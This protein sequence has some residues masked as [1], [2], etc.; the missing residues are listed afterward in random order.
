M[1]QRPG[2]LGSSLL[3]SHA[4]DQGTRELHLLAHHG[5]AFILISDTT[6]TFCPKSYFAGSVAAAAL[7]CKS[8]WR[9]DPPVNLAVTR[10]ARRS[11]VT[12]GPEQLIVPAVLECHGGTDVASPACEGQIASVDWA[13]LVRGTHHPM[14]REEPIEFF[15]VAAVALFAPDVIAAV[16]R[17]VPFIEVILTWRGRIRKMT[18][19]AVALLRRRRRANHQAGGDH[20]TRH[21][22]T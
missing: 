15:G 17:P 14:V 6:C 5:Q 9:E 20:P 10:R 1:I 3:V 11:P 7:R 19:G 13:G 12:A 18:I 21:Q 2:Q 8:F 4:R 22:R 16:R